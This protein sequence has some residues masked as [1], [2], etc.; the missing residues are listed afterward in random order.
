MKPVFNTNL[1]A[2]VQFTL[3]FKIIR[4]IGDKNI[5]IYLK[6]VKMIVQLSVFANIGLWSLLD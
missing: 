3:L 2:D 5:Y 6:D 1:C 4:P